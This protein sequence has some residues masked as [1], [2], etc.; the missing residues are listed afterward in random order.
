MLKLKKMN[1]AQM[2]YIGA[3]VGLFITLIITVLIYYSI[4]SSIDTTAID[5]KFNGTPAAN[6]TAG[7]NSQAQTFF[8]IAPIVGIVIVAVVVIGYVQRI[9]VM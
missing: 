6:A 7:I 8:T 4:A 9:G 3:A 2:S 1:Q 5:A